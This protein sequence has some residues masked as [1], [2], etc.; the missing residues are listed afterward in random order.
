MKRKNEEERGR[1]GLVDYF[2]EKNPARVLLTLK[3]RLQELFLQKKSKVA[4]TKLLSA[5]KEAR[6]VFFLEAQN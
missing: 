1:R 6:Q 2:A 3:V 4:P 5:P